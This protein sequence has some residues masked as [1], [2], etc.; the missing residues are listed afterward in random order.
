[1]PSDPPPTPVRADPLSVEQRRREAALYAA[2][3][4]T[5]G[6][7]PMS[8]DVIDYAEFILTGERPPIV[9]LPGAPITP[10]PPPPAPP[11]PPAES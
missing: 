9:P 3:R 2:L 6:A 10:S 4:M 1:M 7:D 11:A 5:M 8:S